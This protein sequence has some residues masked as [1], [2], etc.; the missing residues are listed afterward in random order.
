M[1]GQYITDPELVLYSPTG[2]ELATNW[3]QSGYY[4]AEISL[5]VPE[6]GTYLLLARSHTIYTNPYGIFAQKVNAPENATALPWNTETAGTISYG[7]CMDTYTVSATAGE[8]LQ[9]RMGSS[10]TPDLILFGPDGSELAR[11]T[12]Y[13]LGSYLCNSTRYRDLYRPYRRTF[14]DIRPGGMGSLQ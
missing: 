3:S 13:H 5:I 8:D 12:S 6:T 4:R 10:A 14:R 9:I 2:T 1:G 11:N 7:G